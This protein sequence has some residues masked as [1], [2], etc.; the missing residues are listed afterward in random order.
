MVMTKLDGE[1]VTLFGGPGGVAA[2][3]KVFGLA[4]MFVAPTLGI[5]ELLPTGTSNFATWVGGTQGIFEVD[6][7]AFATT[8]SW[9]VASDGSK[10][11]LRVTIGAHAN[12]VGKLTPE[13]SGATVSVEIAAY[14]IKVVSTTQIIVSLEHSA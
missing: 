9:S 3:H 6:A 10:V 5:D 14:L 8:P 11:P 2:Y 4:A 1:N 13:S 12:G 7:P